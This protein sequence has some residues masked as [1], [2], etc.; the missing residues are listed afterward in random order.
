MN[1]ERKKEGRKEKRYFADW[2]NDLE[3]K[4]LK[5]RLPAVLIAVIMFLAVC[6]LIFISTYIFYNINMYNYANDLNS[7]SEKVNDSINLDILYESFLSGAA[8]IFFPLSIF[9][10][11]ISYAYFISILHKKTE[12][13]EN[14]EN[15]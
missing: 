15:E 6:V 12:N 14:E 5:N 9:V 11:V 8:I 1:N 7:Y 4:W 3:A 13:E 2:L 10:I